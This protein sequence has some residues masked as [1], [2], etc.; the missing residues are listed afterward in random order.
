MINE[1]VGTYRKIIG[2]PHDIQHADRHVVTWKGRAA[3]DDTIGVCVET[4]PHYVVTVK[5]LRTPDLK[6]APVV[7]KV[8]S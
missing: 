4:R 8:T 5:Q 1:T 3:V 7:F 6:T 2:D